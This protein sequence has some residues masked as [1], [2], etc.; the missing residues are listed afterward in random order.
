M[1]QKPRLLGYVLVAAFVVIVSAKT[2]AADESSAAQTVAKL[3]DDWCTAMVKGDV[4][5][6]NNLLADDFTLVGASG[7]VGTKA[8]VVDLTKSKAAVC[9]NENMKVR[10]YGNAAVARGEVRYKDQTADGTFEFTDTWIKHDGRW[11]CVANHE[12]TSKK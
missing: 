3:E 11:Q 2:F 8:V 6:I 7:E 12:T 4:A 1:F 10:V 9:K 5:A